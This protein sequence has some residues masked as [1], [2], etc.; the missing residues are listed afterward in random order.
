[1]NSILIDTNVL[2]YAKDTSSIYHPWS[3]KM[4]AYNYCCVTSKNLSEYFAVV[5]RGADPVLNSKEALQDLIEFMSSFTVMYPDKRSYQKVLE[6]SLQYGPK[7]LK[8]HDFEIAAI[9]LVNGI[10]KIATVN[11]NDFR[12][13]EEVEVIHP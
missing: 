10:S 5:T 13:I 3:A 4:I 11:V 1:M 7:G 9:G 8:F 12:E 6:L 2:V